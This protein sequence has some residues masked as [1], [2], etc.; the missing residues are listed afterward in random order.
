M[1]E[2]S[3]GGVK[4]PFMG[5][6]D[7]S[8]R[9]S[10]RARKEKSTPPSTS[11]S[12]D[13]RRPSIMDHAE[14]YFSRTLSGPDPKPVYE[15]AHT[16]EGWPQTFLERASWAFELELSMRGIGFTWTTADVRHTRRTWLPTVSNRVHSLFLRSGPVLFVAWT[17]IKYTYTTYLF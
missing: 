15:T 8:N 10:H 7:A 3:N 16:E 9:V 4:D 6:N 5:I 13:T 2:W 17:I 12:S 11:T 14:D 1:G